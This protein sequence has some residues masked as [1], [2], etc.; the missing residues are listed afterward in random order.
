MDVRDLATDAITN[1]EWK[2][3]RDGGSFL[4]LREGRPDWVFCMVKEAHGSFLPDN[5]RYE[6]ILDTLYL[7]AD[8]SDES[9]CAEPDCYT[10]KLLEWLESSYLRVSYC[11]DALEEGW[12]KTLVDVLMRGQQIERVEVFDLVMANLVHLASP[13][14]PTE[15]NASGGIASV[16]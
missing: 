14:R 2:E 9:D 8:G 4:S 7:I 3:N 11:D 15:I 13:Y 6:T 10:N 12:C 1:F 5:F 16:S